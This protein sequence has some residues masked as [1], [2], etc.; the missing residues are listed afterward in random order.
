MMGSRIL[1]SGSIAYFIGSIFNA[2]LVILKETNEGVHEWLVSVFGHHWVGHGILTL[3]V[4]F[5]FFGIIYGLMKE[6]SGEDKYTTISLLIVLGTLLSFII[7]IGFF[8]FLA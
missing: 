5:I 1:Y 8:A 4:F 2:I 6:G 3:L 7:I